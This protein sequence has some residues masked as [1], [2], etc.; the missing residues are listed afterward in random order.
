VALAVVAWFVAPVIAR[1]D[2][3]PGRSLLLSTD[4]NR[5]RLAADWAARI[6]R[7]CGIK[8]RVRGIAAWP[9]GA[10][11]TLDVDLPRGGAT[12]RNIADHGDGLASDARLPHGCEVV[13]RR[14]A[15]RG[16]AL[17]DVSTVNALA[18]THHLTDTTPSTINNP[19]D[20][21]VLRNSEAADI[22]VRF[23]NV[24]VVG[25]VGSGKTNLLH[26]LT[27]QLA[28]CVDTVIWQID[29][30]GGLSRPWVTPWYEDRAPH[31][32]IDWVAHTEAEAALMLDAALAIIKGRKRA[33]AKRMRD[34]NDDKLPVGPDVPQIM[35]M[36]DEGGTLPAALRDKLVTI[37]DT[38]RPAA[39]REIYCAL[40]ATDDY[41][42][43]EL[44]EQSRIRIGQRVSAEK[45]LNFLYGW[46]HKIDPEAAP[47]AG[48]GFL[49]HGEEGATSLV[50]YKSHREEPS[51]IDSV[52][53]TV[54]AWRPSLD[55][56]SEELA[57]AV[58]RTGDA[59]TGRWRR[60]LPVLFADSG[61]LEPTTGGSV[62]TAPEPRDPERQD[63]SHLFEPPPGDTPA[64]ALERLHAQMDKLR[65]VA[66]ED[67]SVAQQFADIVTN[68]E[69]ADPRHGAPA[70]TLTG[71]HLVL[72]IIDRAG[73][74]GIATEAI[75]Q[76]YADAGGTEVRQTVQT[77]L[78][79]GVEAG[80][81]ARVRKGVYVS[82]RNLPEGQTGGGDG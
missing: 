66:E 56:A 59:Y 24:V 21:G 74:A 6:E 13:A 71:S 16:S 82:S 61:E 45:E 60:T 41:L 70:F 62:S 36:V 1:R 8:V 54:A 49:F 30:T 46:E 2:S 37:A 14:G 19:L 75:L 52:A 25:Q 50:P 26:V 72:D 67:P 15:H 32:V 79:Q 80:A 29:L 69:V 55:T 38:G 68:M 48:C 58:S 31:P 33:Y 17:V 27:H 78:T 42:P 44:K 3:K 34:A 11:Y 28:R 4:A 57:D 43:V 23:H 39:V 65:E 20:I 77:W 47:Y 76:A 18:T 22:L 73:P 81:I 12:W 51:R 53:T 9:T 7:V 63:I 35:I 64:A 5:D 40:R 10:G